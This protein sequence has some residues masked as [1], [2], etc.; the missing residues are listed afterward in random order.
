MSEAVGRVL[1]TQDAMPLEFW[2]AV[3]EG[4]YLQLD[5]VVFVETALPDGAVLY[6]ADSELYYGVN[7]VGA[8]VWELLPAIQS[9]DALCRAVHERY[10]DAELEQIQRD[11]RE[12]LEQLHS[13]GLVTQG[14]D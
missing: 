12:L 10:P 14:E 9:F 1:G 11:V 5:D 3:E 4:Q 6:A 7:S 2:V 13:F 8:L